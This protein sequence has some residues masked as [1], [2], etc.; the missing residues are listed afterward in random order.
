[1]RACVVVVVAQNKIAHYGNTYL[2]DVFPLLT[3]IVKVDV[4]MQTLQSLNS[5]HGDL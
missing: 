2:E 4:M 3:T 5:A 1:M